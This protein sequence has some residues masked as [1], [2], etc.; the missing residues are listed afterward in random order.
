MPFVS[1]VLQSRDI[2]A[3]ALLDT[4]GE[5]VKKVSFSYTV[6]IKTFHSI[7]QFLILVTLGRR[8]GLIFLGM[9]LI[10]TFHRINFTQRKLK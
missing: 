3:C 8:G 7:F 1:L 4:R 5:I 10:V 2:V 9:A 6:N